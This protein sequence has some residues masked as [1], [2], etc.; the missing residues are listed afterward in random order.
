MSTGLASCLARR[1]AISGRGGTATPNLLVADRASLVAAVLRQYN[2]VRDFN[3]TV[4]MV[5]ALGSAEKSQITEYK[6]VRA[7]ILFRKP[8][9]IRIIGLYPVVRSKAFDMVSDG[10]DFRLYLPGKNRFLAG[11]NEIVAPSKNKLENLRPEH[12]LDALMVRPVDTA[13]SKLLLEN[14]TDEDNAFY[15]LHE[16]TE[17]TDGQLHLERTIWFNRVNLQLARQLIFDPDGN[18][19][20]DARYSQWKAYDNVPFPKHIEINRPRDEYGVVIDIVKMDI[21]KGV[22]DDKFVLEQPPGTTLQIVGQPPV[23]PPK[24]RAALRAPQRKPSVTGRMLVANLKHQPMRSLLSVL[25]IGVPV[26][27]ILTLVGLSHGMLEDA[28]R[29]A[30]GIGADIIVRGPRGPPSAEHAHASREAYVAYFAKQP[31]VKSGGGIA[32]ATG[33]SIT[34]VDERRRHRR[35]QRDERRVQL[36]RG[37]PSAGPRWHRDRRILRPREERQGGQ[38]GSES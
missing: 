32:H 6:D 33:R 27:L 19:L 9:Y 2:A 8:A 14:F 7:F 20:T 25:L 35:I 5:P 4:D 21:N 12:F 11:R 17:T 30:R 37:R 31:H 1:R 36:C 15:I 23:T 26:T 22:S 3:A 10:T 18:I 28:A 34:M 38:H 29:R 16:V 13:H 24:G